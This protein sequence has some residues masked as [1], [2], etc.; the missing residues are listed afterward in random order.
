MFQSY[1]SSL[2]RMPL[3]A[4]GSA[5]LIAGCS[6]SEPKLAEGPDQKPKIRKTPPGANKP[7]PK[8]GRQPSDPP[9]IG[10]TQQRM[11]IEEGLYAD[12]RNARYVDGPAAGDEERGRGRT[13]TRDV[14]TQVIT[15]GAVP[16]AV[17]RGR[18]GPAR[19]DT[20]GLKVGRGGYVTTIFFTG[21]VTSLPSGA[22]RQI[23]LVA[24]LLRY[25]GGAVRVVGHS[26]K[27]EPA[28]NANARAQLVAGGLRTLGV[29]AGRVRAAGIGA[30]QARYKDNNRNARVDIYIVGARRR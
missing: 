26:M 11:E 30:R 20:G 8:L 16:V 14:R 4:A 22:G 7:F 24:Q 5:A 28:A 3:I 2:F 29:P 19:P 1:S 27:G 18:G 10:T 12:R 23:V 21:G 9:Q 13:T 25:T 15:P 17:R 6:S